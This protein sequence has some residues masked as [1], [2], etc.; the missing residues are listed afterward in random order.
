M[1]GAS[2]F[3]IISIVRGPVPEKYAP[4]SDLLFFL[5]HERRVITVTFAR[6]PC[7]AL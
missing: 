5:C 3:Q 1:S 6:L 2:G 4:P 7:T